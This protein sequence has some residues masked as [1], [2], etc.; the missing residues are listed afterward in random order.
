M[1]GEC[2]DDHAAA[3]ASTV[4]R[5]AKQGKQTLKISFTRTNYFKWQLYTVI[6]FSEFSFFKEGGGV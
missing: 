3:Q 1:S 2:T 4:M 6:I 5:R